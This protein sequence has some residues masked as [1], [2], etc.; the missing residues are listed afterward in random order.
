VW[1]GG[2]AT[3]E[4]TLGRACIE[5]NVERTQA[6]VVWQDCLARTRASTSSSR[7][8]INFSRM[9]E[10]REILLS[11][12]ETD[13]E[14]REVKLAKEQE[15]GLHFFN[16]RDLLVEVEELHAR[17]AGVEDECTTEVGKLLKLAVEISNAL[18]DLG[19]LP[20][21]DIPQ[22]PKSAQEVL[23][24]ADLILERLQEG[25]ASGVDP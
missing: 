1:E 17:V 8:S 22:L 23:A 10:E 12:H 16:V 14:V 5:H 24:V 11:L 18:V 19:L 4:C 20:I 21:L 13:L 6:E 25:H 15:R 2:L 9:L 3:S 7:H